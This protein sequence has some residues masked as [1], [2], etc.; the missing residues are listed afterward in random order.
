MPIDPAHVEA[1]KA[2]L[3]GQAG[4][5]SGLDP[6]ALPG[7]LDALAARATTYTIHPGVAETVRAAADPAVLAAADIELGNHHSI[8][9]AHGWKTEMEGGGRGVVEGGRRAA[10]YLLRQAHWDEASTLLE[11]MLHRDR[12]PDS[13]AFALPLLRRIVEAT[14]GTERALSDAGILASTLQRAGRTA[15]AEPLLRDLIARGAA[16]GNYR[17]AS[18]A[19]NDLVTLLRRSGRLEEALQVAEEQAGY[20]ARAGLG[21][22]KQLLDEV[23]RLQVLVALGRYDEVLT[24]FEALRPEMEALSPEREADEIVDPWEVRETLLDT[25]HAAAVS[26]ERWETALALNAEVVKFREARG[27]GEL[28][29]ART[30]FKAYNPLLRLGRYDDARALLQNCR[31]VFEAEQAVQ[32]M[33]AVYVALAGLEVETGGRA[34]AV[35]FAE[36]ALGY[37]YQA[38]EPESCAISHNNLANYLKRQGADPAAVLAHRLAAAA[39]SLQTRSGHL[40]FM[41]NNLS[42]SDLPPTPPPFSTVAERV[43]AIEGVRFQALFKRLPRTAPDGDAALAAVW[44]MVADEKRRRDEERKRQDAVLASAPAAV[45]AAFEL[46]GDEFNAA[47][48]EA[49]AEMP[50]AEATAL[51]QRLREA[52]LISGS[53]GPDMKQVLRSWEPLL[54]GIAAAVKDEGLRAQIEPV[55]ANLEQNGWRLT[56]AVHCIWAGEQDAEALTAGIDGN[57]AQLVRRVLKL[58][59]Q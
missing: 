7:L 39:I 46:E 33:G 44:Q 24:A 37:L 58:L 25:G 40:R 21:P 32:E 43:E 3:A 19:A 42:I 57:S 9:A 52:G 14:A 41:L 22:W 31:A 17:L 49:L 30:R 16:Q 20:T 54:Q 35:R 2:L 50:E 8:M 27:A 10:P 1:L 23:R 59:E 38:G 47:L 12:S 26:S 56:E 11:Q 45:R 48:R 51:K 15:E 55:L 36:V 13:L 4:Q 6:A 29:V 18:A 28:V 34:E 53:A 5:G